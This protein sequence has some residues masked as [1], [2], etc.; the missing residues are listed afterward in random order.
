MQ[1]TNRIR[2]GAATA[3]ML[4]SV[5]ALAQPVELSRR[6]GGVIVGD[7]SLDAIYMTRDLNGDG[8]ATDSGESWVY[9]D[10][11]NHTGIPSPTGSV[12]AVFQSRSGHVFAA[13]SNAFTVY[14]LIDTNGN[15]NAQDVFEANVWFSSARNFHRFTLRF[16]HGIFQDSTGAT[17]I[18]A[19]SPRGGTID[20]VY[21]TVDLN[22]DGD[23]E[24]E[25]EATIWID[26][27]N[28]AQPSAVRAIAF[29][30]DVAY[31]ADTRDSDPDVVYRAEDGNGDGTIDASE[32]TIFIDDNNPY[33]VQLGSALVSDMQSLYVSESDTTQLQGVYRLTDLDGS[34]A[35]DRADEAM[36]VW[37][38][39]HVPPGYRMGYSF[40][41][42][43]GPGGELMVGSDD[44][45]FQG[46]NIFRLIDLNG[47]GD[48]MDEGETIVWADGG[49]GSGVFIDNAR[50]MDY[51]QGEACQPCDMN[52]DGDVNAFDIEPFLDL[53]FGPNPDP[54]DTC[55]GD[56]NGDGTVDAFD[57]EPFLNCLFP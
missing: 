34:G 32:L 27:Q 38:E 15:G 3:T 42:A 12:S 13:D 47:D 14:R 39:N 35:I 43:I 55:T 49:A 57:V 40:P 28:I 46:D 53:L 11:T 54:C 17:Y 30:G 33:G 6:T 7:I 23:A 9:F 31:F 2:I 56:A 20:A 10:A 18:T 25:N 24:D 41:M 21:R 19:N 4:C 36:L 45:G 29:I 51:L 8:D 48:F 50:C 37:D 52:C 16:L 5:A 1:Y 26:L 44:G 22:G